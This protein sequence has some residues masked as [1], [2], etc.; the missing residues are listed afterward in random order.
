MLFSHGQIQMFSLFS[1]SSGSSHSA[2]GRCA[3]S[4]CQRMYQCTPT[5][6]F[7]LFSLNAL[8]HIQE[9]KLYCEENC[10][11]TVGCK[12]ATDV[13]APRDD[14]GL[15]EGF[16][17]DLVAL[18]NLSCCMWFLNLLLGLHTFCWPFI[19]LGLFKAEKKSCFFSSKYS[20]VNTVYCCFKV[21]SL[22]HCNGSGAWVLWKLWVLGKF[23]KIF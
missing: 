7:S 22:F 1:W 13:R 16:M 4:E 6:F 18:I 9:H 17:G 3:L 8:E 19:L 21:I 15:W 23:E 10:T 2:L 12:D 5:C 14:K 11:W 20:L